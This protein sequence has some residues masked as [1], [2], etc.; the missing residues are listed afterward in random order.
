MRFRGL[1][2]I[3]LLGF[4]CR[5]MA[6]EMPEG[7]LMRFPDIHQ[8]QIV[9][10]YAGDLWL[11]SNQGGVARRITTSPGL[12]LFPKFSPDGRQIAFTA[13]YDGN[14]NVYVMPA[15]GGQPRQ[16]TFNPGMPQVPERMGIENEV[17]TWFPDGKRILFLSRRNT[18]NSWFG[19]LFSVSAQGG[20]P[21]QFPLPRGGLTSF[22]PDG[23]RIAYNRIFRNFRTWKRYT[24]GLAQDIWIYNLTTHEIQQI[25]H[26]TGTDTFPMWH[27]DTIYFVSDR[28]ADH[29]MNL[30]S[31]SLKSKQV[32]QLTHFT[33][34]DVEWPSL[35]GDQIVFENGGYLYVYDLKSQKSR[36]VQVFL[37]GD[38]VQARSHWVNA[39]ALVTSMGLSPDGQRAVFTA[40]GDVFTV[41]AKNGSIRDLTDTS[42]TR[43]KYATWSPDGRWIAYVS[44]RSGEDELYLKPQDGLGNEVR[45]T[46][47]GK[48]FRLPPVWSPDSQK[49]LFA[50]KSLRLF[51]VDIHAKKPVFIDQ[52]QYADLTDYSWSPDSAWVAYAKMARNMNSVIYLYSLASRKITPVTTSFWNSVNPVFDPEGRYLYFLS[53]RSYNAVPDNFDFEVVYPQTTRVYAVT[54][55]RDLA[56]PFAPQSNEVKIENPNPNPPGPVASAQAAKKPAPSPFRVDLEGIADRI[57]ALPISPAHIEHLSAA[58]GRV[59][60]LTKPVQGLSGPLA[61]VQPELHV[62]TLKDRKDHVLIRGV[63][64]YELSFDGHKV[65]YS[66]PAKPPAPPGRPPK[67]KTFGIISSTPTKEPYKTGD[68]AL[69]LTTMQVEVNPSEEWKQIFNEVWRQERDYFYEPSMN[70]VNWAAVRDKY[71]PLL[72]YV[73]DRY[74]LNY[75]L[76]EMIGELGNSHTYVGGGDYPDLHPVNVGLLGVDFGLDQSRNLYYFKKIYPGENWEANLRSPLTEPGLNV[77]PGDYLLAVNGHSLRAPQNPYELFVNTANQ[78]VTL[79]LSSQPDNPAARRNIVVKPL[80]SEFHLRELDWITTNR[81]KVEEASRGQ[82]GYIYLPDMEAAGINEFVK[83]FYPQIRKQ[84]LIIDVRYNGGGFVDQIILERLRRVLAAMEAARNFKSSTVPS[85]V[86]YGYMAAICNHFTASDGDYFSYFFRKYKLGTLIGT[87]TWGGVR[88]IRGYIPLMDGGYITRPEFSLY[89]LQSQWVIENHG[90]EPDIVVDD[91]PGQLMEGHD[92]QLEKAIQILMQEIQAHPKRLPPRPPDLP[93]Y[94]P[95]PAR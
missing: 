43:E 36:K 41:P 79:T 24:G 56:S 7:R 63:D 47:D 40:R 18:F 81:R 51:Y 76:G 34:F 23:N 88:G 90:V 70:G 26:Y 74:D 67:P 5:G 28:D 14:F 54:L 71:A 32:R 85:Q 13:Q 93:P 72:S 66:V 16:L 49:L 55:R 12:E 65:L 8:N 61:G 4:I 53:D 73:K 11:V 69:N 17:I 25:T 3:A 50:D 6:Q 20:L 27:G 80:V 21:E 64:G 38:F 89:N 39:S 46:F 52:G 2:W 78:N 94:P 84:G 31:Y 1:L 19:R 91:L 29:R 35:G 33:D 48:M 87:R 92:A 45:V 75:I 68:G 37:P 86:F 42:G 15:E 10:S 60:Y 77:K 82:I 62:F 44:D 95:G 83:Q 57:V 9:F 30:Y 58:Q 59:Y 22:S